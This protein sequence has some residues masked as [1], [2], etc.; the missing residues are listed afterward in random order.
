LLAF[1]NDKTITYAKF[2]AVR[3]A[4]L[5]RDTM[6]QDKIRPAKKAMK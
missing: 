2:G 3:A 6:V 4:W 5:R 1:G